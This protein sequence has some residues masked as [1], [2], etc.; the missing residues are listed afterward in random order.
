LGYYT[1]YAKS[2]KADAQL[3]CRLLYL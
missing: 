3:P 2:Q 1:T